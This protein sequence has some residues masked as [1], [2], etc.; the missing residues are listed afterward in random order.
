[1]EEQTGLIGWIKEHKKELM[2]AGLSIT[3]VL[4]LVAGIK[5]QESLKDIWNWLKQATPKVPD[6]VTKET[7]EIPPELIHEA[8][9][10]ASSISDAISIEVSRHIRNLPA[11]Q[12][13][14]LEKVVKAAEMGIPL[15][16]GQ[17]WVDSYW[18]G[19]NAA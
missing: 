17:T 12:H 2:I 15:K 5:K 7:V 1:M 18:K 6:M 8:G 4:L 13:P 9:A 16:E 10:P 3:A 11:G 14:S 19:G